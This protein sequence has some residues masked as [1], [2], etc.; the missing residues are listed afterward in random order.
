MFNI[1]Y[2]RKCFDFQNI[3]ESVSNFETIL[4]VKIYFEFRYIIQ[5]VSYF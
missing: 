3:A 4:T 2:R 5:N 1:L